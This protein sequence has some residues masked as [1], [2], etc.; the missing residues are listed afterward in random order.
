MS[1]SIDDLALE[2]IRMQPDGFAII[3]GDKIW[4]KAYILANWNKD[5]EMWAYIIETLMIDAAHLEARKHA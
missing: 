2:E 4:D 3:Q 5:D 1:T